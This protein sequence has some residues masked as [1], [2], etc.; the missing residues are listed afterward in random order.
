MKQVKV[1]VITGFFK[2]D[3]LPI[4]AEGTSEM[5]AEVEVRGCFSKNLL[6]KI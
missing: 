3:R 5:E 4:E 2:F 6:M 1:R